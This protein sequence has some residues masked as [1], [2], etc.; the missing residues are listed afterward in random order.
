MSTETET[1]DPSTHDG[2]LA[3]LELIR[4]EPRGWNSQPA[5]E[6]LRLAQ[7]RLAGVARSAEA[8]PAEAVAVAW[9]LWSSPDLPAA[10]NLWAITSHIVSRALGQEAEAQRKLTSVPGLRRKGAKTAAVTPIREERVTVDEHQAPDLRITGPALRAIRQFVV[11]AG[12]SR[13]EAD[14]VL[15]VISERAARAA[16]VTS[17]VDR[18]TRD[19]HLCDQFGFTVP[20]W[21]ALVRLVLGT[22]R[23]QPGVVA[24]TAAGHPNPMQ[25]HHIRLQATR[26]L[27]DEGLAVA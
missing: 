5:R 12:H 23:G 17:A 20:K 21:R 9:E 2:L 3:M 11:M 1:R 19:T 25:V 15:G 26:F 8:T 16:T 4:S 18:L 27:A 22:T 10:D 14:C 13:A 24:L 6:L 7:A